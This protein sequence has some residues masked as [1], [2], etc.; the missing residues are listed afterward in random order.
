MAD[1]ISRTGISAS[2]HSDSPAIS[3]EKWSFSSPD[4]TGAWSVDGK[5]RF[6]PPYHKSAPD[7]ASGALKNILMWI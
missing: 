5:Y 7:G 4:Q 6:F 2:G 1:I 3:G